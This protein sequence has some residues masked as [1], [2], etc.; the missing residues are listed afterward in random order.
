MDYLDGLE[1]EVRKISGL[2]GTERPLTPGRL[3]L[4][5]VE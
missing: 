3:L 5:A 2:T 1:E 4:P